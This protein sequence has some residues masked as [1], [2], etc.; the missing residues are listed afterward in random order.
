M[1]IR[2]PVV[3]GGGGGGGVLLTEAVVV[4]PSDEEVIVV[5][6]PEVPLEGEGSGRIRFSGLAKVPG[7]DATYYFAGPWGD[8]NLN[9]G[10]AAWVQDA[11]NDGHFSVDPG[12]QVV[13]GVRVVFPDEGYAYYISA[14]NDPDLTAPSAVTLNGE[15]VS[16]PII[17]IAGTVGNDNAVAAPAHCDFTGLAMPYSVSPVVVTAENLAGLGTFQELYTYG[18][19]DPTKVRVALSVDDG[20]TWYSHDGT[21]WVVIALADLRTAGLVPNAAGLQSGFYDSR[22]ERAELLDA[23]DWHA[24]Y[25]LGVAAGGSFALRVAVGIDPAGGESSVTLWQLEFRAQEKDT[26]QPMA[27]TSMGVGFSAIKRTSSTT[28]AFVVSLGWGG[29]PPTDWRCQVWTSPE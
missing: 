10:G 11:G 9:D 21:G 23:A 7:G 8:Q 14:I 26:Y 24:L 20:T 2:Q 19:E 3:S 1:G 6:H 12:P 16:G 4:A 17:R 27:V 25:L 22:A 28:V 5:T 18:T 29:S 13:V 15:M